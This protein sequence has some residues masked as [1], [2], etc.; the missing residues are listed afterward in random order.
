MPRNL[1]RRVELM[2]PIEEEHHTQKI[3]QILKLQLA[4]NNLN[5]KLQPDGNYVKVPVLGKSVNN[6]KILENYTNKIH[7]KSNKETPD[8]VN[9]LAN[10]LLKES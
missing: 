1:V 10:R 5:W 6:H 9:R 4:D 7:N 2:T 8:Y 3:I